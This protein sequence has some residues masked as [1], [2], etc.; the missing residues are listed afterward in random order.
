[1]LVRLPNWERRLYAFIEERR[2]QAFAMGTN[3]CVSFVRQAIEVM[4]GADPCPQLRWC[5]ETEADT[6]LAQGLEQLVTSVLGP[7]VP[8]LNVRR[9]GVLLLSHGQGLGLKVGALACSPGSYRVY[10]QEGQGEAR[11]VFKSMREG[12]VFLPLSRYCRGWNV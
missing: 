12:L 9:G 4:T 7:A 2:H 1:M 6:L 5:D 10:E 8:V 11:R 3:D